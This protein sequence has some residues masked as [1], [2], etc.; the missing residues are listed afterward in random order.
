MVRK[1]SIGFL[2]QMLCLLSTIEV[3]ATETVVWTETFERDGTLIS[4]GWN[5][6]ISFERDVFKVEGGRLQ[7]LC[8]FNPYKGSLYSRSI[9]FIKRGYI[10]F[11]VKSDGSR[12]DHLSLKV[13]FYNILTSFTGLGGG[14]WCRYYYD[15]VWCPKANWKN[16]G[17]V[18][19]RKY[20]T[21]KIAFDVDA[22]TMEY[23]INDMDNPVH[24]DK[25]VVL[26]P[27]E[28]GEGVLKIGNY[29]LSSGAVLNEVDNF[30]LVEISG[31]TD[32]KTVSLSNKAMVFRGIAADLY[33]LDKITQVL[34]VDKVDNFNLTLVGA[35]LYPKNKF[36]LDRI[37]H[38][39]PATLPKY[40]ILADMPIGG[41]VPIETQKIIV[42]SVEKGAVLFV[43]GGLFTLNKG[44]FQNS[45]LA[46]LLPV[47]MTSPWSVTELKRAKAIDTILPGDPIVKFLHPLKTSPIG[48]ILIKAGTDPFI[49]VGEYGKG[50]VVVCLGMPCGDFPAGDTPFWLW[51]KWPEF[52]T[53]IRTKSKVLTEPIKK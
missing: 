10:T 7:A 23:Y 53:S 13:Y 41:V 17:V 48:K 14:K 26:R 27:E 15:P 28:G 45:H 35:A 34:K 39:H 32:N 1:I 31:I 43:F 33:Q 29:G 16:V 5:K 46:Q 6:D 42:D 9:P 21:Y 3:G 51:S 50:M 36:Q 25:G 38:P 30:R 11:D 47:E 49:V 18:A 4:N 19:R 52:I 37:P 22:G 20:S 44:E 8:T 12:Y 40:I 24:I 2:L